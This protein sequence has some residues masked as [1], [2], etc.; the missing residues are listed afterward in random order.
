MQTMRTASIDEREAFEVVC[1][2][3]DAFRG[4]Q[5]DRFLLNGPDDVWLDEP[6]PS[7]STRYFHATLGD[8]QVGND[9]NPTQLRWQE[10]GGPPVKPPVNK[11]D[12]SLVEISLIVSCS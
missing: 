11:G 4:M 5:R 6:C 1:R 7:F 9:P 2:A 10:R 12:G 8:R 3:L